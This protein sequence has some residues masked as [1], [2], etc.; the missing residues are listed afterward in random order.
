MCCV[1]GRGITSTASPPLIT[2]QLGRT[3]Y[4]FGAVVCSRVVREGGGRSGGS[5]MEV[6]QKQGQRGGRK[7]HLDFES[8]GGIRLVAQ[9]QGALQRFAR[10]DCGEASDEGSDVIVWNEPPPTTALG[11]LPGHWCAKQRAFAALLGGRNPVPPSLHSPKWCQRGC[12]RV[13]KRP[14]HSTQHP[15]RGGCMS[16]LNPPLS[17]SSGVLHEGA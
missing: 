5:E 15:L 11:G 2:L 9:P 4:L 8:D 6:L 3:Q 1:G 13:D 17:F 7:A 10:H 14:T 16:N 12:I